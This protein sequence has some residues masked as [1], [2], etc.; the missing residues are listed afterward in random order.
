MPR[1]I[2]I[3]RE[4]SA[5]AFIGDGANRWPAVHIRLA[6]EKGD[7]GSRYHAV[8]DEGIPVRELAEVIGRRLN[9]PTASKTPEEAASHFGF[10]AMF[11][12]LDAPASSALTRE[13]LG[14]TPT[15][16]GL[17]ADLEDGRYF[18]GGSSKYSGG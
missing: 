14:W 6:L 7:A 11:L 10:L 12:G 2:D 13:R 15:H 5:S 16:C 17:V 4:T 18:D 1:I 8:G 3:A 9:L